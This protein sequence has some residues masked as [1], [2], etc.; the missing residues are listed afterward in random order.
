MGE[1]GE[2]MA[3]AGNAPDG[4]GVGDSGSGWVP[5]SERHKV[6]PRGLTASTASKVRALWHVLCVP[7]DL[8]AEIVA[9]TPVYTETIFTDEW[10]EED[11]R[12]SPGD[13]LFTLT[14]TYW[15]A[16]YDPCEY[17]FAGVLW[18][19]CEM[20]ETHGMSKTLKAARALEDDE[21]LERRLDD[22]PVQDIL[23]R[24][25]DLQCDPGL[26]VLVLYEEGETYLTAVVRE[27]DLEHVA[28]DVEGVFGPA[29]HLEYAGDEEDDAPVPG[30]AR[31]DHGE[32]VAPAAGEH[33]PF[34]DEDAA[35]RTER[36]AKAKD[37]AGKAGRLALHLGRDVVIRIVVGVAVAA[38]FLLLM[39]VFGIDGG[40]ADSGKT[41]QETKRENE[42]AAQANAAANERLMESIEDAQTIELGSLGSS[43]QTGK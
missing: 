11:L 35:R 23:R 22:E 10:S 39:R 41:W 12:E 15:V 37:V 38:L 34:F 19:F 28:G 29:W 8:A 20:L 16:S 2:R 40:E 33:D 17:D 18:A 13:S 5:Y 6:D 25:V 7:D 42:A 9:K 3:D 36:A 1:K 31:D 43:A 21:E 4:P 32:A 27:R 14:D 30:A 26:R 24:L